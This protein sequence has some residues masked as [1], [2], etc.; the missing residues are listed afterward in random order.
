MWLLVRIGAVLFTVF[1]WMTV[2]P[3]TGKQ[4]APGMRAHLSAYLHS[5]TNWDG[6]WYL[7][8]A[9]NG[10]T[11]TSAAFDP[12]F[13]ILIRALGTLLH[14]VVDPHF[15]IFSPFVWSASSL[16]VANACALLALISIVYLVYRRI[17][18]WRLSGEQHARG[19]PW[20]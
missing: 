13:P 9:E 7:A 8:I 4:I 14:A 10:Y 20:R 11:R 16:L 3:L 17:I 2:F 6:G 15:P 18:N 12:L 5:W 19:G 1:W